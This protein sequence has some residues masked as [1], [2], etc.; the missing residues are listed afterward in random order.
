MFQT[1]HQPYQLYL[2]YKSYQVCPEIYQLLFILYLAYI[3]S[4]ASC[5]LPVNTIAT[6]DPCFS[7]GKCVTTCH[8]FNAISHFSEDAQ[9]FNDGGFFTLEYIFAKVLLLD[10]D[11]VFL[12]NFVSSV[13]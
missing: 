11:P 9:S 6:A 1:S 13:L 8:I 2:S 10:E 3:S 5:A 12:R 7:G 4:T